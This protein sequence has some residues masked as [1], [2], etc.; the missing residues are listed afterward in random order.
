MEHWKLVEINKPQGRWLR[1]VITLS[2]ESNNAT[3]GSHCIHLCY[4]YVCICVVV[5]FCRN[6]F[7]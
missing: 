2:S 5:I 6:V 1:N 7:Q 3:S 4:T